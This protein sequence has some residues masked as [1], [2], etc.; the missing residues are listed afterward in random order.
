M[1]NLARCVFHASTLLE[2]GDVVNKNKRRADENLKI[3]PALDS[4][5]RNRDIHLLS[6]HHMAVHFGAR[7][8]TIE[9]DTLNR[10][11]KDKENRQEFLHL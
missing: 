11:E 6:Y 8:C 2:L 10:F 7:M 4:H 1:K 3:A 9:W 5:E